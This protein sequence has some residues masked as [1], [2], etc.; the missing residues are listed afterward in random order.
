MILGLLFISACKPQEPT[1]NNPPTPIG[2]TSPGGASKITIVATPGPVVANDI[3]FTTIT[4]TLKDDNDIALAGITPALSITNTDSRN[5]MDGCTPSNNAGVSTCRLYST[6]AEAKQINLAFPVTQ[7]GPSVNFVAGPPA[8]LVITRQPSIGGLAGDPLS[9]QPRLELRDQYQ[10]PITNLSTAV[11]MTAYTDSACTS[12]AGGAL[13]ATQNPLTASGFYNFAGVN[14]TTAEFIHLGFSAAGVA[15]VC[16]NAIEIVNNLDFYLNITTQPQA[17]GIAGADWTQGPVLE[18][19]DQFG[20]LAIIGGVDDA[21]ITFQAYTDPTCTTPATG[22]LNSTSPN[23][24]QANAAVAPMF[25][26][27]YTRAETFYLGATSP[28]ITETCTTGMLISP[29]AASPLTSTITGTGPVA[30]NNYQL[31]TVTVTIMDAFSNPRQGDVPTFSATDSGFNNTYNACSATDINGVSTCT[32]HSGFPEVKTLQI[33]TPTVSAGGTVNFIIPPSA[34]NTTVVGTTTIANDVDLSTI[35][36]TLLDSVSNPVVG[37]LPVFSATDTDTTNTQTDCTVSNGAGVSTCTL[38]SRKAEMKTLSLSQPLIMVGSDVEFQAGPPVLANSSISATS[39][40]IADGV[41]TSTITMTF[42]DQFLNDVPGITPTFSATD[43]GGTNNPSLCSPSNAGGIS[44]CTLSSTMAEVKN[45]SMQTPFVIAGN[46]IVFLPGPPSYLSFSVQPSNSVTAGSPFAQNPTVTVF[47][48]FNNVVNSNTD[49]ITLEMHTTPACD[50]LDSGILSADSNPVNANGTTGSASFSG[51][52]YTKTGSVHVRAFLAGGQEGCSNAINI[53]PDVVEP[54]Q[55]IFNASTPVVANNIDTSAISITIRDQY[56]NP[57]P[58]VTPTYLAT[59]TN[60]TNVYT[61]CSATDASGVSTCAL[62]STFAELKS[63]S[64]TSPVALAGPNV[65][66]TPGPATKLVYTTQPSDLATAGVNFPQA[67]VVQVQDAFD[68]PLNDSVLSI[69]LDDYTDAGCTT[70]GPATLTMTA[71]PVLANGTSG[72]A[73]FANLNETTAGNLHL[74]A[75]SGALTPACSNLVLVSPN[76]PSDVES[77]ITGTTPVVADDVSTSTVTIT[78]RDQ[79]TNPIPGVTPTFSATD[80]NATNTIGGCSISN[81]SGESTCTLRSRFAETKTLSIATPIVTTGDDV[82]F[83]PGAAHRLVYTQQ[84]SATGDVNVALGSQPVVQ[85]QDL[86]FNPVLD[87]TLAITLSDFTDGGCSVAGPGSFTISSNPLNANGTSGEASFS[88][89]ADTTAGTFHYLAT[90]GALLSACSNAV[91]LAPGPPVVANSDINGT[92]PHT[93][94]GTDTSIISVSLF[95]VYNN[96]V[97]GIT[98]TFTATD[99]N[100]TNIYGGCSASDATGTATCNLRSTYAETKTLEMTAPLTLTG[101]DVLFQA[102]APDPLHSTITATGPVVADGVATSTVTITLKDINNNPVPGVTPTYNATDT[103]GSNIYNGCTA[104]DAIGVSTCTMTSTVAEVKTLSIQTPIVKADGDVTFVAGAPNVLYSFIS[105]TDPVTANGVDTSVVTIVIKDVND[106]PIS[107]VTPTFSATDTGGSNIYNACGVTNAA[108]ISSC[109]MTSVRAENKTLQ[110][111]NP[112]SKSGGDVLFVAGAPDAAAS[113]ISGTGPIIADGATNST[114]TITLLDANSNPIIGEVP[115]FNATDTGATNNYGLCSATNASGESTCTLNSQSAEVKTLAITA[116]VS[117]ADGTV[118]FTAGPATVANSNIVGTSPVVADDVATSTITITLRDQFSN[119]VPGETPTF[120]ATD[121]GGTNNYGACSAT[122][123]SGVSTCTM[124]STMAE[125]K[126][127]A[128]ATPVVKADG[129]VIF[130]AGGASVANSTITGSSPVVADGVAASTVTITLLDNFMNPIIGETPSFSATNTGTTN[131][132]GACSATNASGVSTCT[133]TSTRAETKILEITAPISKSDGTVIFEPGAPAVATSTISGTGPVEA[134]GVATSTITITLLDAFS[135]PVPGVTPTFS[136]TDT[137][138]TNNPSAC[139]V[140]DASGVSTC[141]LSSERAEVKTLSIAT[142]INKA[143][144]TVTFTPGAISVANSTINGSGPVTANGV[145]TSTVTI[146]LFDAFMNPVAGITPT[147]I[148]TNSG[149]TNGYG[150]CSATDASGA[151]TCT[152]TSERAE[153]KTLE[154]T[155][156]ISKTDGSVVF[157]AGPAAVAPSTITGSGPVIANSVATS[158]ITITLLDQ[159]NNP[160]IGL[161]PT[162][163]ATDTDATNT[164]NGCSASDANGVSTCTMTSERAEEK[165]LTIATPISKADG[166]VTFT[167]GPATVANSNI[168]GTSPVV[169]DDVATSTITIT[170][171]DQFSNPVPGETPTFDATDTGGTNNYSGCS[172]TD[173][174]GVSTCTMRSTMAEIKTLAITT[175][176]AKSDGMVTF[177]P[178]GASV[179]NSSITGTSPVTADGTTTSTVTITL[180]DAFMNPIV[181]ET[182]TFTATNTDSTNGYSLCSA[183]NA[184]GVSTCTLTSTRAET[185]ILEIT[186]PISKSDGTVIFEPGAP[187][188]ATSTISG[189]GPVEANGVATSAI[190]ITLLDAFSNPVPGVTPTFTATDTGSTN[191]PSACSVTDAS[192]VSTCTLSSERA[193]VKTLSI[194]TPINKADGTV[195]FTSGAVSVANSTINGSGPVTANGVDT[196]TV[197]IELFDAFMNPVAGITPTFIATNS[198]TTNGYGGCSAT[199]ASGASTCTLTSERAETKTLEITSPISKTDGSV[200]FE[201]GPA[202]VAPST[203]T[204]SGPVLADGTST[205]TITITLLDQFSNPVAA[206]TPTFTATDTGATNTYNGCSASD[207][208]GVST[209]TMTSERAE[210]KTL[211]IATPISKVDGTVTFNAGAAAV[212]TS[213]ITGSGPVVADGVQTSTITI[214][215]LDQYSNPVAGE[216]PTFSATDGDGSNAQ[217][218][219]SVSDASGVSTCTLSSELAEIKT[220]SIVTPVAKSD[221]TV[222][223]SAGPADSGNSSISGTGSVVADGVSISTITITLLDAFSNPVV[224]ETP[225]FSATDSGTNN[226]Y[227]GCSV[228][229]V[230]GVSTCSMTSERAEIKTLSIVTPVAKADGT[231][232]FIAG[233]AST[234]TS[235]IIG[236]SPVL[237]DGI[238]KSI[239]TITLRDAFSNP[240]VGA[241]PTFSATDTSG[242]NNYDLCSASDASGES[243]CGLQSTQA[244]VKTLSILTPIIMAGGVVTFDPFY[245][246]SLDS[247]SVNFGNVTVGQTESYVFRNTGTSAT[248]VLT[249]TFT[250][251]NAAYWS[252]SSDDCEGFSLNPN[253]T[254][255]INIDFTNIDDTYQE[256]TLNVSGADGGVQT[257]ISM[258]RVCLN[259]KYILSHFSRLFSSS[260][261]Q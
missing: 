156:P 251:T 253:D 248:G 103:S 187:A 19:I 43:T 150:G 260:T 191:S 102:G 78:L 25:I 81:A 70:P 13:G 109:S 113:L 27:D 140:T 10:N 92:S 20:N 58:G 138:S 82:D 216:T 237:A 107:G 136:A 67:P 9:T 168:V 186:A 231:V 154:I 73:S 148:A 50:N 56:A 77:T 91:A 222:T 84:P 160:V 100:S 189:T 157:E 176:V 125:T 223:F 36:I 121:T 15:P 170:L 79:F 259:E 72:E 175:P 249:S 234:A 75:S 3:D 245:Q 65:L 197:T 110:I 14:Y 2:G 42:Q 52:S 99:T 166:T 183:T 204:G 104:T 159:F 23:P 221:G 143:D 144:G 120:D 96:A 158:T 111:E 85:V 129:S 106:N 195:S 39:N 199:D 33:E 89:L 155:S 45:L 239:I 60:A 252:K 97:S 255:Q 122:D 236:T 179:A 116:P 54:T 226:G 212:A 1:L 185:K 246:L 105:G 12:L 256:A 71:N 208:S 192:G 254:C 126:T 169:A 22:T 194:A 62:T 30:A 95:D 190:T 46:D 8:S 57:I 130:T 196:S 201:A 64:M 49:P 206:V 101:G 108:G 90:S 152:L 184:S 188:V 47:D 142:P 63:F 193:E 28:G 241:T 34:A 48:A 147:F 118:T 38:R 174:S 225:T 203:I 44:T 29:A 139:S 83:V 80:T 242:G 119:P 182:P 238:S 172:V 177:T 247:G 215:L 257:S 117:K 218:A 229:D 149:T 55:I 162:F 164:Y 202:A 114:V 124:R 244:E 134:N 141:T 165:T 61:A 4:I 98:P 35:T 220:L 207:A 21:M 210:V 11:T 123:A 17:T 240:V 69:T 26:G 178:G 112:V 86:Y 227:G 198:G 151:S 94:D 224:G 132:Y 137:G 127:L 261:R 233:S 115:T 146:E 217:G 209:C 87:S 24:L 53:D 128:I 93:A 135:N 59:D 171:R 214:T 258:L 228:S 180:L 18:I 145:D 205:S 31:S 74:R 230:N 133:L 7:T 173:A 232:S 88:N 41:D 32:M 6:R 16:T 153:T 68:N 40:I 131:G 167:A 181:G 5:R 51:L 250:P 243:L 37:L 213:T 76:V 219:C 200:V 163:T 161:T 211:T 235:T 66:F